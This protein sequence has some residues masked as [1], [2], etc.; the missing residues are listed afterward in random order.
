MRH[1]TI[2]RGNLNDKQILVGRRQT[3]G[4]HSTRAGVG[5]ILLYY[6]R[7]SYNVACIAGLELVESPRPFECA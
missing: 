4:I 5:L 3:V 2:K 7:I 1:V 6:N